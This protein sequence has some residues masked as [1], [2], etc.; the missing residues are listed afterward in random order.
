MW[1][2]ICSN[3]TCMVMVFSPNEGSQCPGCGEDGTRTTEA[4]G[5]TVTDWYVVTKAQL[6]GTQD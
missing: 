1:K 5:K 6:W 4:Q 3:F 2:F